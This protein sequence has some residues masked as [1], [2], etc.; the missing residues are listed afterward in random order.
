MD[1]Y[2]SELLDDIYADPVLKKV[3]RNII[4][5]PIPEAVKA[6]LL[7]P[8]RP[9]EIIRL[10]VK[11]EKPDTDISSCLPLTKK[12]LAFFEATKLDPE[13]YHSFEVENVPVLFPNGSY[14]KTVMRLFVKRSTVVV[15][16]FAH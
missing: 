8:L 12:E 4:E 9:S 5:D 1:D 14:V 2:V 10:Q 6:R 7:K 3:V 13:A 15:L 11:A 16:I